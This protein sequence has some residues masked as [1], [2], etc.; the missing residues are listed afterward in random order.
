MEQSKNYVKQLLEDLELDTVQ[1][2]GGFQIQ[3]GMLWK[4]RRFTKSKCNQT[5]SEKLKIKLQKEYP[6]LNREVKGKATDR[7]QTTVY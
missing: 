1:E 4:K 3:P 5:R 2:I 6:E 7:R